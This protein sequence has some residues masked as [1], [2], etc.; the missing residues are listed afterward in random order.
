MYR[1]WLKLAM[2]N[3]AL[4]W[5]SSQ[6]KGEK[7]EHELQRSWV[8]IPSI[9]A[10]ALFTLFADLQIEQIFLT[11]TKISCFLW[12]SILPY[13]SYL[14]FWNWVCNR[15]NMG[16]SQVP[17]GC[18][19]WRIDAKTCTGFVSCDLRAFSGVQKLYSDFL[20]GKDFGTDFLGD[21]GL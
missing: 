4:T 20:L 17:W 15:K 19:H 11:E 8:W 21:C 3:M 14:L 12:C 7:N 9:F 5:L 18:T 16:H 1:N 13:H 10:N 6:R 2:V